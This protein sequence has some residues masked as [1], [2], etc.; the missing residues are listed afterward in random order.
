MADFIS[1]DEMQK[2]EGSSSDFISDEQM[3]AMQPSQ[4]ESGLRGTAQG[5]TY[6]LADEVVG[7][8][9]A[10]GD[11][12][13][14]SNEFSDF[15]ELYAKRRDESRAAFDAAQKAN[16]VA[17]GAG[18]MGGAIGSS[19]YPGLGILNAAK[20]ATT[21]GRVGIAAAQGGLSALGSSRADNALEMAKDTGIGGITGAAFQGIG[22]KVIGPLVSKAGGALQSASKNLTERAVGATGKQAS[23][24]QP[25]TGE[26]LLKNKLVGFGDTPADIAEKISK[27]KNN[28]GEQIDSALK[29]LDTVG[30]PA[31]SNSLN[32]VETSA[33]DFHA[34]LSN[35]MK[36][37]DKVKDYVHL[38]KNDEYNN[39]RTFLAPDRKSGYAIKPDGD[40]VSVFSTTKG[41]G[42]DIVNQAVKAGGTKLDAFDGYLPQLYGKH[43]FKEVAREANWTPGGP[44]VVYMKK[45]GGI[46]LN[47]IISRLEN[48]K[49]EL[50]QSL[51][52]EDLINKIQK[53]IDALYER[54]QSD[55]SFQLA[56]QSKRNFAGH[57]NYNSPEMD[58]KAAT[59]LASAFRDEVE[60]KASQTDPELARRFLENKK[61][62][63]L[64]A[65]VEEAAVARGF[66]QANTPAFGMNDLLT[67]GTS[68]TAGDPTAGVGGVVLRR[69]IAPRIFSSSAITTQA[70]GNAL[71]KNPQ[72]FGK[73]SGAL[74]AAA[75]RGQDAFN[76]THHLLQQTDEGY[77]T[78][79]RKMGEEGQ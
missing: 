72:A 4:L 54:G 29:N 65:P 40:I 28:A 15:P 44:D 30:G 6:N 64:L 22:E 66:Q 67:M 31:I 51:G 3:E 42:D 37:S 34:A 62:F 39:M 74:S 59:H 53:E 2:L 41:R 68:I 21:L 75:A 25:G 13:Q 56:E 5:L 23:K 17:Y 1:D 79:M 36:S 43:G 27:F 26:F 71:S 57:V 76:V 8:A 47:N 19:F 49:K 12:F 60:N 52:N 33:D 61:N 45:P 69:G 77:R 32:H 46:D 58:K 10:F 38:Y 24:F 48:K 73:W 9:Q 63:G 50:N 55:I 35:A 11:L 7:G 78:M 16:P 14:P 20:G 18:E 70:I